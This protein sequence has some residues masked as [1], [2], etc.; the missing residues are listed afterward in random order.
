MSDAPAS[1]TLQMLQW[2]AARPRDY[3]EVMEAWRTSCPRLTI[4]EDAWSE[5]LLTRDSDT[6]QVAVS[7]KGRSLLERQK[8]R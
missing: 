6:G 4:W 1:L 7:E 2:L 8:R 3:R 5:G